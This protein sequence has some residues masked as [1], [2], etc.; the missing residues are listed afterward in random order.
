MGGEICGD[1]L[2][3]TREKSLTGIVQTQGDRGGVEG[4]DGGGGEKWHDGDHWGLRLANFDA[5]AAAG[6]L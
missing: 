5:Q 4:G 2:R 6:D 3:D 1:G